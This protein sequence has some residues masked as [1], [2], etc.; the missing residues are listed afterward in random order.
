M[1]VYLWFVVWCQI[2]KLIFLTNQILF[3]LFHCFIPYQKG[4]DTLRRKGY[5][6]V[7][8]HKR[9]GYLVLWYPEKKRYIVVRCQM[10][11][12]TFLTNKIS[13]QCIINHQSLPCLLNLLNGNHKKS[14]KKEACWTISNITAGN[15]EQIQ[16]V[17]GV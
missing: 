14:I 12:L 6:V 8:Y 7:W 1:V 2:M 15:R 5:L 13:S 11:K 16:V 10:L 4:S 3:L 9:K 17:L